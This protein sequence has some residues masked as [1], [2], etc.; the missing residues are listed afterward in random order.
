MMSMDYIGVINNF[1]ETVRTPIL[2]IDDRSY[3]ISSNKAAVDLLGND[4]KGRHFYVAIRQPIIINLVENAFNANENKKGN[5]YKTVSGVERT[6][7]VT[8]EYSSEL[9]IVSLSFYD[10]TDVIQANQMRRDFVANVSH[11][12]K[13]PLTS[14]LGFIETLSGVIKS[15]PLKAKEF[16]RVM[17]RE[18]L[19]MS[20]LIDDLLGLSRV[21][22]AEKQLP[23]EEVN[24]GDIMREV[25]EILT[26]T[27]AKRNIS[28]NYVQDASD[29]LIMG[30]YSQVVQVFTNLLQNAIKYGGDGKKIKVIMN[31]T[32]YHK[33]LLT[34]GYKVS[35]EDTG[36]GI[37]EHHLARLTERFY[38]VDNH[39]SRNEGGTGLGLS[40][41][42]HIMARHNGRLLIESDPGNGSVFSVIFPNRIN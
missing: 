32:E 28:I 33:A 20:S 12:L 36:I 37:E 30:D 2:V 38:R 34:T 40:I 5:F 8:A 11:E 26:P 35:F 39:R 6:Y 41:V 18:S 15:N 14:I 1:V 25:L 3:V 24:L 42:K 19:R 22:A 16:L 23:T 31:S 13:S 21:E 9:K 17:E 29:P 10:T 4:F 27:A 7:K